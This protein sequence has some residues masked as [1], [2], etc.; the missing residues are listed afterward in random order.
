MIIKILSGDIISL[1]GDIDSVRQKIKDDYY[2]EYPLSCIQMLKTDK[3]IDKDIDYFLL[4]NDRIE[5]GF[6]MIDSNIFDLRGQFTLY[7]IVILRNRIVPSGVTLGNIV[8]YSQDSKRIEVP[9]INS[10]NIIYDPDGTKYDVVSS[11]DTRRAPESLRDDSKE[12]VN[13]ILA[14]VYV[15]KNREDNDDRFVLFEDVKVLFKGI[16]T[17][18]LTPTKYKTIKEILDM[19]LECSN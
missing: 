4:V 15:S 3:D 12:D 16:R 9:L 6:N 7:D 2:P 5:L 19:K 1:E 10:E 8:Y 11:E 18:I 14:S 17:F 13:D